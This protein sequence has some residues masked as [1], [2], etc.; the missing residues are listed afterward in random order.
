MQK[1]SNR[2]S[3]IALLFL[4]LFLFVTYL[5][6]INHLGYYNDDWWQI[7]GGEN[8]GTERFPDMYRSDRPARAY[9]HAPLFSFF[10]S[11]IMPYQLL[12]LAIR[13]LGAVGLLWTLSLIWKN[14]HKEIFLMSLLFLIYP[15]YLQQPNA[16]DY[17]SHQL[18]IT[19]MIFSIG[20]SVKYFQ[21]TSKAFKLIY[22]SISVLFSLITFFLMDY[23][24]GMEAYRWL[25]LGYLQI[26]ENPGIIIK[27]SGKIFLKILPFTL[28]VLIFLFWR[29]FLFQGSRYT[30]DLSRIGSGILRS[31]LLSLFNI[32]R[33]WFVDVGDIFVSI[34]TEPAYQ[35]MSDLRGYDLVYG[36]ILGVIGI[37]LIIIYWRIS[38]SN[39]KQ[40]VSDINWPLAA[41]IIGFLGA[42]ICLLPINVAERDV[43]FPTFNRFSFPSA[44]GVAIA[45]I[46]IISYAIKNRWQ[47]IF[48]SLLIFTAILTHYTNQD[49]FANRWVETQ[50][51]WQ[52]W[53]WRVPAL[54]KGTVLSGLYDQ[55]IQEGFFI[56]APANLLY[57]SGMTDLMVGAEVLNEN[58]INEVIMKRSLERDFRSFEY[59]FSLGNTLAFSKP[60]SN[61]CLRFLDQ[62]QI[63]LSVHDN[64]LISLI[65]SY[66]QIEKITETSTLNQEMYSKL[67]GEEGSDSTWCY[68]YEKASLARQFG[69]WQEI[70]DLH[71]QAREHDLRPYDHIEWFP[72]LQAYAYTGNFDEV[73]QL[74]PI[75]NATPYYSYQACQ[76]FSN[77]PKVSD[78]KI[79]AGNLYLAE[80]FCK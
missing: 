5:P 55:T 75:I 36:V 30:T 12:A 32:L 2:F 58:T 68:I 42:V 15:G 34:W 78:S 70:I 80:T 26:K 41:A 45:T 76:L 48:Y 44:M 79:Q 64:P 49:Y 19:L 20:L 37:G 40:V 10:G 22:F 25:I 63:E 18:A 74:A 53:S 28:P 16:F 33:R 57:F 77:K 4:L 11:Q 65:A 60:T 27:N 59:D 3:W 66:S 39:D 46:A 17:M 8:F 23:Y 13:W 47:N 43:S 51:L 9:L 29:I 1:L 56:W 38:Q 61:T 14:T 67:F 50:N 21:A 35:T 31:P 24:L 54:E 73:D 72:F 7:Y 6:N 69:D 71:A 62:N 52:Q